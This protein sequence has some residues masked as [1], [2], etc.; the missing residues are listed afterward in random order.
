MAAPDN[1]PAAALRA[2]VVN[3]FVNVVPKEP[4]EHGRAPDAEVDRVSRRRGR[5]WCGRLPLTMT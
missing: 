4:K 1:L 5:G 2:G 3:R